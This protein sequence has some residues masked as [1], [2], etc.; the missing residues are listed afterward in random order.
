MLRQRSYMTLVLSLVL[1]MLT[2]QVQAQANVVVGTG[3]AASC[4]EAALN[5]AFNTL[6]NAGSGTLT[7]NCGGAATIALNSQK[8]L[9]RPGPYTI[10]GGGNITLDGQNKTRILYFGDRV[11]FTI[12]NITLVN[13]KAQGDASN[14]RSANQG[15]GI[16]SGLGNTITVD[17]VTFRNNHATGT[18]L[19]WQ[20]GG[21]LRVDDST[22][23]TVNNSRFYN[24]KANA[25]GAINNLLS[26]LTITNSVFDGNNA[27]DPGRG[28]DIVGG[29]AI[30]NDMGKLTISGS[31][32]TNNSAVRLGGAI[33]TWAWPHPQYP[34]YSGPVEITDT[35]IR[36]NRLTGDDSHG[37]GIY[38]GSTNSLTLNRVTLAENTAAKNGAGLMGTDG[39]TFRIL[40]STVSGN[41]LT[42]KGVGAGIAIFNSST[43]IR[44]ATFAN[45]SVGCDSGCWANSI[46]IDRGSV[47]ITSTIVSNGKG[48]YVQCVF[49]AGA[50]YN[51][52]GGNVETGD[53]SCQGFKRADVKLAAL[54]MNGGQTPTHALQSGSAAIGL[55]VNCLD[56]DQRGVSRPQ[57][58][59]CDSGAFESDG[60]LIPLPTPVTPK[61]P[62]PTP[63]TPIPTEPKPGAFSITKP[64]NMVK[65]ERPNFVWTPS[66][67]ADQYRV[68]LLRG[69]KILLDVTRAPNGFECGTTCRLQMKTTTR[70]LVDGAAYR[71]VVIA[72]NEGGKTRVVKDFTANW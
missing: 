5:D 35:L 14:S 15:A 4:T 37:G 33:Y 22:V 61:P 56:I 41:R 16:Y 20:G 29:G 55:G 57:G 44:N 28:G 9:D 67:G 47:S 46:F 60:G 32:F 53:D 10:D 62:T 69:Q 23:A 12:K 21:A 26:R 68:R 66:S 70:K 50:A 45:N 13:G 63:P 24:N 59:A 8:R 71:L 51:N 36:G 1:L 49:N 27:F 18:A 40:N 42:P 3:S 43:T 30:Y 38:H 25:G 6:K 19:I 65:I 54:S 11:T 31:S 7:F 64:G 52:G 2:I 58:G 39:S 72:I 48:G 34:N 17:N